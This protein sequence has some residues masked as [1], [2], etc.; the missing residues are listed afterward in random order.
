MIFHQPLITMITLDT[1][2][3]IKSN[4]VHY[5]N[6]NKAPRTGIIISHYVIVII[7]SSKLETRKITP[8]S[9]YQ[10]DEDG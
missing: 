6:F 1:K 8:L 10:I 5:L 9:R 4:T 2:Q 3:T 7:Y